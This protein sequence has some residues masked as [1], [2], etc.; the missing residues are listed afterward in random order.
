MIT[1]L[2]LKVVLLATLVMICVIIWRAYKG[3]IIF[4][5]TDSRLDFGAWCM[6]A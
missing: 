4:S 5:D 2:K 1:I 6:H 3:I